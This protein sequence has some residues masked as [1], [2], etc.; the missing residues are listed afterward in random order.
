MSSYSEGQTHQLME[1]LQKEGFT[2]DDVTK[3][4]QF[5]NLP[6]ILDVLHGRAKIVDI[7]PGAL[8]NE[9]LKL[10]SP[11]PLVIGQTDGSEILADAND[12]FTGGIDKDFRNW[13]ADEPGAPTGETPVDVYEMTKDATFAQM[14]GSLSS[15][16]SRLC[17]TQAQIKRFVKKH[18][19]WLRTENYATFFLF[20]SYNQFFVAGV[21]FYSDG[22]LKVSVDRVEYSHVWNAEVR[23]R[24]AAPRLA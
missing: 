16:V 18:R 13:K 7:E 22:R 1:A 15:D 9:F 17:L 8:K 4:G 14:F 20:K 11:E 3:L 21:L 12:V 5:K 6:R 2:S 10:I 19:D 24:L 23:H